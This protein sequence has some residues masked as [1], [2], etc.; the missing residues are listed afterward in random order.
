MNVLKE[1]ARVFLKLGIIGFGGPAAHLALMEREVVEKKKWLSKEELLDFISAANFIPGPNSTE[2]AIHVGYKMAGIPGLL[3]AGICFI[4]PAVV[5]VTAIAW[6]YVTYGGLPEVQNVLYGIKPVIIAVVLQALWTLGRSALKSKTLAFLCAVSFF[7]SFLG[8]NEILVIFMS[9]CF[10]LLA[11]HPPRNQN[12]MS[13]L[14][15]VTPKTLL[16]T[17]L[18][19]GAVTAGVSVVP[20]VTL[21]N[22]FLF[23]LKVGSVLFGSGY[24]L[25]AFLRTDFVER[26]HWLSESQ[27]L[28]AIAVGQFTPGPVFTTATFIGYLLAGIKGASI[29]T[30][31][32]FLPAF[33]FVA[34]SAPLLPRLRKSKKA[35]SFLDGLNVAS[36]AVMAVAA[37]FL[38]KGAIVDA[39]TVGLTVLSAVLLIRYKANSAWLVL[40]GGCVGLFSMFLHSI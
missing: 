11:M 13:V 22:I 6:M 36:L 20:S 30:V 33:V 12:P 10:A 29:A 23:F 26:W 31:G 3:I 28:D 37:F 16:L 19:S 40:L 25:V 9:G 32:I 17:S 2:V 4:I 1:L 14:L 39:T 35:R 38:A 34:V 5:I 24:V 18:A 21:T 15:P 8:L 7:A 27:L